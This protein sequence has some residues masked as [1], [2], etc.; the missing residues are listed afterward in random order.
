MLSNT[1]YLFDSDVMISAT[2]IHYSPEFCQVFWDWLLQGHKNGVFYSIDKVKEELMDGNDDPLSKWVSLPEMKDFFMKSSEVAATWGKLGRLAREPS[3][4]YKDFAINKFVDDSKADA[5]LISFAASKGDFVIVT[6][7]RSAPDS[8]RE[9]KLPD[10]ADWLGVKTVKLYDLFL[11]H[12][13]SNFSWSTHKPSAEMR[14]S[15]INQDYN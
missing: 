8:K 6:N 10:A 5:W 1:R 12:A 2:R 14:K 11:K 15:L 4:G 9:I 3:R 13:G 7:E